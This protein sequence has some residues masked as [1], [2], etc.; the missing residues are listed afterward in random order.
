MF[1]SAEEIRDSLVL[2][3]QT[4][5]AENLPA[6]TVLICGGAALNLSELSTRTTADVDVIGTKMGTG[7]DLDPMPD[8]LLEAAVK[9]SRKLGIE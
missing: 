1:S 6:I 3:G 9:V 2:L 5:E 8:W 4:L 7:D